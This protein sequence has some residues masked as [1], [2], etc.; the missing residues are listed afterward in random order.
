MKYIF[1]LVL[2]LVLLAAIAVVAYA[3]IGDM[4]PQRAPVSEPVELEAA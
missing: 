3:Y 1:R 2:I 4:S